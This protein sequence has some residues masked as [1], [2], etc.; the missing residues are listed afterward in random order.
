MTPIRVL[1][2]DDHPFYREGVRAMFAAEE[3]GMTLVA[4]ASSGEEA[5]ELAA[6][7]SP[8]V[9]LMDVTMPG[10]GGI[11]ATRRITQADP[12]IGVL[13]LTMHDD[14]TVFSAIRAGA[15]GY[16][17]KHAG[18]AELHRAVT[19]VHHGEAIFSPEIARRIA[20]HFDR[21]VTPGSDAF[22]DLTEREREVLA[23]LAAELDTATIA[24]RLGLAEKTVYN[25][26]ATILAK[27]RARDRSEAARLARDAGLG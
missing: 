22:P 11:E 20:E 7:H 4:E 21:P 3:H 18:F 10:I 25:Y 2:A 12:Q 17:L 14:T 27:L 13:V 16:L 15:R 5:V 6:R 19:A 9:V 23:L 24:R 26:V 1:L 8:D